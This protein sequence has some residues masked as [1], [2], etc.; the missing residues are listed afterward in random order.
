[1]SSIPQET[2]LYPPLAP[3]SARS[4]GSYGP[5]FAVLA[6]IA[7]LSIAACI[8]ARLCARRICQPNARADNGFCKG[9]VESRFDSSIPAGKVAKPGKSEAA[10][11]GG[12]RADIAAAKHAE[13]KGAKP[14]A[15]AAGN[16]G[17]KATA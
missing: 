6:V 3:A 13:V 12:K 11:H 16:V 8:I 5:V 10:W 9:D 2:A 7:V 14:A 4:N 1:M 17:A 15:Y